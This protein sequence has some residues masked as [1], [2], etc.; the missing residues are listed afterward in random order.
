MITF[1]MKWLLLTQIAKL[2]N[3][4]RDCKQIIMCISPDWAV[5]VYFIFFNYDICALLVE[6]FHTLRFRSR[7]GWPKRI[8]SSFFNWIQRVLC[9]RSQSLSTHNRLF[10]FLS[11]SGLSIHYFSII[12]CTIP[13]WLEDFIFE[14]ADHLGRKEGVEKITWTVRKRSPCYDQ[15]WERKG[16]RRFC[17]R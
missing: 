13:T 5:W 8:S 10:I 17:V 11:L 4:L 7:N 9:F 3:D 2:K 1:P 16:R 15:A 12:C 6:Y 14:P